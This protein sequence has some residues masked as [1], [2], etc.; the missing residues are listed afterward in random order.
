MDKKHSSLAGLLRGRWA[1]SGM[2]LIEIM[3]ALMIMSITAA[4]VTAIILQVVGLSNSSQW[5]NQAIALS[6]KNLEQ[7]RGYYQIN[8]WSGVSSI[9]TTVPCA[10]GCYTNGTLTAC[11]TSCVDA[12]S[13][14]TTGFL[15]D[16]NPD[17]HQ[18]V[19][20]SDPDASGRVSVDSWV[21]WM[22]KGVCQKTRAIT[23]FYYY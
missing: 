1:K 12:S 10:T 17:M 15:V 16:T 2:S 22:V 14:C 9:R 6:E 13:S 4:A 5:Q 23:Y 21:S 11:A 19:N 20:I 8:G 18:S 3:E 7:V